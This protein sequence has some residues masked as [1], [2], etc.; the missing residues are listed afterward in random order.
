MEALA[1][2]A[3]VGVTIVALCGVVALVRSC[4]KPAMKLSRSE[5]DLT[6]LVADSLPTGRS[7]V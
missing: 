7:P 1:I 3:A 6:N 5:N 4:N 2:C